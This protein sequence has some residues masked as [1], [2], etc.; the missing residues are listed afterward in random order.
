MIL[1]WKFKKLFF[2]DILAK[3]KKNPWNG[4]L[5]KSKGIFSQMGDF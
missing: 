1:A 4:F 3:F 2:G 5:A